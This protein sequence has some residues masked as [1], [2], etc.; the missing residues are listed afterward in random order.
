MLWCLAVMSLFLSAPDVLKL[1]LLDLKGVLGNN[2]EQEWVSHVH[3]LQNFEVSSVVAGSRNS[4]AL[5]DQEKLNFTRQGSGRRKC[6]QIIDNCL[7]MI[8]KRIWTQ[9]SSVQ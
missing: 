1:E 9:I 8:K 5:C 7:Q 2:E 4:L 6:Y 3:S